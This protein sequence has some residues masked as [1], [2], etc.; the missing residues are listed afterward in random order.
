MKKI[1]S[2]IIIL[3]LMLALVP[4]VAMNTHVPS[5]LDTPG[6]TRTLTLPPQ[7][8]NA[9]YIS[10]GTSVDPV[11][12][13]VVEGYAVFHHRDGHNGG[14]G[15]GAPG[16]GGETSTCYAFLAKDAKW[17]SVEPWIVN[18]ANIDGLDS[19]F[20]LN[21]LI[22]DI[23]KWEDA[24]DGTVGDGG[25]INILGNGSA[26]NNV[27][28]ADTVSPDGDNEVY[29]ADISTQNV[30]G[31]T[32]I[33]GIFNGPPFARELV[34]WDQVYDDVDFD[35]DNN[36]A[37]DKMD[38]ENVATHELGHSVGLGDLYDAGC[39]DETMY[40]ETTEGDLDGRD[41]NTGDITGI[42]KLY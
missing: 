26:T 12:G 18:A 14:P 40:G 29:F 9:R 3:S 13:K 22:A 25:S 27:L 41:L 8:G 11:S 17:K 28:V 24:A 15:G 31:V 2:F 4:A 1:L 5:E 42:S 35:W 39:S 6:T 21:D 34:E 32:I 36:G 19:N 10:L 33:W 16:G 23:D 20:V 38:F 7:A 37:E 30:I